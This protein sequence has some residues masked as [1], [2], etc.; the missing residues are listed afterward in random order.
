MTGREKYSNLINQRIENKLENLPDYISE[1][2]YNLIA[3]GMSARTCNEYINKVCL[4]L[5]Y[6]KTF[7]LSE[8]TQT[9][10]DK[11]FISIKTKTSSNGEPVVTSDSYQQTTWCALNKFFTFLVN[12]EYMVKNYVAQIVKPKNKDLQR[13]NE[14]RIYLTKKDFKKIIQ[15][16][17]ECRVFKNRLR[18]ETIVTLLMATGMRIAALSEINIE[19][20]DLNEKTL[21]VVDKGDK[22]HRYF[23]SN[24]VIELLI[25]YLEERRMY[26]LIKEHGLFI[27]KSTGERMSIDS[28]TDVVERCTE[29]ALGTRLSPHKLRAGFCSILYNET[30]DIEFVRRAV[31][32]SDVKTTQ[33]Y[34]SVDDKDKR[35]ASEIM[36]SIF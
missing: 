18:N 29:N 13:I 12:R 11:Y 10:V 23:L 32:H 14:H 35:K 36:G 28:I 15:A 2:Y 5:D 1:W 3:S 27:S 7:N 21:S 34:I 16:A 8:I 4:F 33:R 26:A 17:R 30:H 31:G 22:R 19:D 25:S 6:C 24:S 20:I 9:M